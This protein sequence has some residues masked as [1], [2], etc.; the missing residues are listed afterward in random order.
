VILTGCLALGK[1]SEILTSS[2]VGVAGFE[3]AASSSR[4]RNHAPLRGSTVG[5]KAGSPRCGSQVAG[6]SGDRVVAGGA[7]GAQLR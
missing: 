5:T 3:P 1:T 2:V 7:E 6:V 4:I